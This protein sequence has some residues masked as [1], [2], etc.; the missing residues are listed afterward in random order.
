MSV[1]RM[2]RKASD[3]PYLHKDFHRA[4]NWA[5]I[6]L[7]DRHGEAAVREYLQEFAGKY[8][9]PLQTALRQEGLAALEHH[10]SWIYAIEGGDVRIDR[11]TD[12]DSLTIT[13]RQCPAV[14][15]IRAGGD[16]VSPLFHLTSEAVNEAICRNT[17]YQSSLIEYDPATGA[18]RQCFTRRNQP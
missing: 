2:E 4:L 17:P 10:F 13:V 15:H 11:Q 3:N 9:A 6:Y 7:A 16:R 12:P 14:A 5:L 1:L 18:C 8:Y